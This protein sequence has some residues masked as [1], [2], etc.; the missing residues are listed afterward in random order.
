MNISSS[1]EALNLAEKPP[2]GI[3]EATE[4]FPFLGSLLDYIKESGGE[5]ITFPGLNKGDGY[6]K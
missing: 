1:L 3:V 2:A 6:V 4:S 5:D